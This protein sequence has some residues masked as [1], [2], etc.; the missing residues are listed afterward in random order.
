MNTTHQSHAVRKHRRA[1]VPEL[2]NKRLQTRY[3]HEIQNEDEADQDI[4]R[5][6]SFC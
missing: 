2:T 6:K 1:E 5:K 3:E 4:P